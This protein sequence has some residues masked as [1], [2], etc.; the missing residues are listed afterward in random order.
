[1]KSD[2]EHI[3]NPKSFFYRKN[4]NFYLHYRKKCVFTHATLPNS[5]FLIKILHGTRFN[6]F[7]GYMK[8]IKLYI[9]FILPSF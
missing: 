1:M 2:E 7:V 8:Y 4:Y 9:W 3:Q 5:S 6:I